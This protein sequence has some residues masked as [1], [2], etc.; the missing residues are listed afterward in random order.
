[1]FCA[2][3]FCCLYCGLFLQ[4]IVAAILHIPAM[5]GSSACQKILAKFI[6]S[7]IRKN[8]NSELL[9]LEC[10]EDDENAHT[11][12]GEEFVNEFV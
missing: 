4:A 6:P 2:A 8:L 1:L 7:F 10:R 9:N 12:L 11:F 5:R 3:H